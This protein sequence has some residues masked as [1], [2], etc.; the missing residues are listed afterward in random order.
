MEAIL[1]MAASPSARA[2]QLLRGL[3][4]LL[5]ALAALITGV[6]LPLQPELATYARVLS[7]LLCLGLAVTV[8]WLGWARAKAALATG[9]HLRLTEDDLVLEHPG[10]FR[11]PLRIPRALVLAAA[12][13]PTRARAHRVG[14]RRRFVV[15]E[16]AEGGRVVTACLFSSRHGSPVPVVG[17]IP[18]DIPNVAVLFH[19]PVRFGAARRG[20]SA[21]FSGRPEVAPALGVSAPGLLVKVEDPRAAEAALEAWGVL[22]PLTVGDIAALDPRPDEIRRRRRLSLAAHGIAVV[23]VATQAAI[24]LMIAPL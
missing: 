1:R 14:D 18:T 23:L 6:A 15:S 9:A 16:D 24:A 19:E 12:V 2:G 17:Q 10:L 22:R 8:A 13:D 20:V 5:V 3:A 4:L 7:P 21:L 11:V